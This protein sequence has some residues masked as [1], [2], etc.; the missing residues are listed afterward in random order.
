MGRD[1]PCHDIQAP[2]V[3]RRLCLRCIK[4]VAMEEVF[5]YRPLVRGADYDRPDERGAP[6]FI[7]AGY[8][9]QGEPIKNFVKSIN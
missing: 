8:W 7:F 6:W 3:K 5:S 2:S 4:L 1:Y 9:G